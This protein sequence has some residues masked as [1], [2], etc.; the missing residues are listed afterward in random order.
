LGFLLVSGAALGSLRGSRLRDGSDG[1][2][3]RLCSNN[4]RELSQVAVRLEGPWAGDELLLVA[5]QEGTAAERETWAALL[6]HQIL[7]RRRWPEA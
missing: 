6:N 2:S 7:I 1:R 4:W 5:V 3:G